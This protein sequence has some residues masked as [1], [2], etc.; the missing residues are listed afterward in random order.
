MEGGSKTKKIGVAPQSLIRIA[1]QKGEETLGAENKGRKNSSG[2][3]G[4]DVDSTWPVVS[5]LS[6][7]ITWSVYHRYRTLHSK[8]AASKFKAIE[9]THIIDSLAAIA[10]AFILST[11]GQLF[12]KCANALK[13]SE[14]N[15]AITTF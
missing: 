14:S 7:G 13:S 3:S 11:C 12:V 6:A 8:L 5:N 2:S 1:S 15:N 10:S 4:G 9:H